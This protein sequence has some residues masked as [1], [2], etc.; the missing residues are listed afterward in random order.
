ML[1]RFV[2]EVVA[3]EDADVVLWAVVRTRR[4]D[5]TKYS[6]CIFKTDFDDM[7]R[8]KSGYGR[9][10]VC[11]WDRGDRLENTEDRPRRQVSK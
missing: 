7:R 2:G 1:G 5:A 3:E 11:G 6:Y 4:R 10:G 8:E 9:R